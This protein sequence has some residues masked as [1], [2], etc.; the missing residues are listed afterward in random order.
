M[1]KLKINSLFNF[2]KKIILITGSSGQVGASLVKLFLDLDSKVYGFDKVKGKIKHLNYKFIKIDITNKNSVKNKINYILKKEKKIDVIINSAAVSVFSK[3]NKRTDAELNRT[4]NTNIKGLLNTINAY[5]NAHKKSNLKTCC[6]I[7]IGSIYGILS[8]DF[9]IYGKRDNYSSE[10]YGAT[11]AA[12]I[13]LTKYY[14]VMLSKHRIN[15]NCLS[16]GGIFNNNKPQN[17]KFVKKY[18]NRVPLSRMGS[19][20][21]LFTG[22]LF[23]ASENSNYITGQNL[24]IDGGLSS[25]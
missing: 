1:K 16:P 21:N 14:S 8:P 9:R 24:I 3:Y 13:Q 25:W 15:V 12:V 5:S 7:N 6:I 2:Q 11:K 19:V 20:E 18:S 4:I 10:I 22:I 17:K 23:L